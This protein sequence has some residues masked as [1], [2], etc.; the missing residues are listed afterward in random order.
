M[1]D[2]L[3]LGNVITMD[4]ANSLAKAIVVRDGKIE[5]VGDVETAKKTAG[6]DAQILDYGNNCIYPGFLEPHTHGMLAGYRAIGQADL[7]C[8]YVTDYD[9]YA[10][11]MKDFIAA[12][13]EK[14]VYLAAG[15]MEDGSDIDHTYLDNICPDKPLVMNTGGGHSC[16]LNKKAM[17]MFGINDEAL[18]QYGPSLIH[19]GADGH[20]NGYI[21]EGPAIAVFGKVPLGVEDVKSFLLNWQEFALSKGYTA[22]ADAGEDLFYKD[23]A[24]AYKELEDEGKLKLRTFSYVLSPDNPDDPAAVAQSISEKAKQY[25]G[26]YYKV[27]GIKAFLDGVIEAHTGW[28][29]EDYLDEPGYHGCERFNDTKKMTDLIVEAQKRGLAVH[30][31]SE[32]DGAT[33][34]M[35]DCIERAQ[36]VTGD[37]DQ[38]NVLA[39]LHEVSDEDIKKMASTRSIAAVAPLWTPY[40]GE[41][42]DQEVRFIGKERSDNS[43]PIKSFIDAGAV[44]VYHSDYP[45]SPSVD[46]SR[47]IFMGE[48]RAAPEDDF[49]GIEKSQRNLK[50]AVT[51]LDS[52]RSLTTNVA[53]AWKMEDKMGSIEKGK[54][55]NFAVIDKNFL[56][57]DAMDILNSKNIATIVDGEVVYKA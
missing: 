32:G 36:A 21:C 15:W 1:S 7:S 56:E 40:F 57:D 4:K 54:L 37:K 49:G 9:K 41:E 13:P 52:L 48:L 55:A 24:K 33:H 51:R 19:V 26:E 2:K 47:S 44:T 39:H 38:R 10:K 30:V 29:L 31:H 12:H 23:A 8:V 50:E 46:I 25:S 5:Y 6:S 27:V 45:I 42:G 20:P 53:Y 16:L 28:L 3:I 22:V 43:Y 34:F 18:K 35:L 17:E 11:I 14:Q